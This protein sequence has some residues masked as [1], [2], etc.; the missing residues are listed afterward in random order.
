MLLAVQAACVI[1][2]PSATTAV[3]PR[4]RWWA[5]VWY[6]VWMATCGLVI[7]V[8]LG[9]ALPPQSG[10]AALWILASGLILLAAWQHRKAAAAQPAV[11]HAANDVEARI[12]VGEQQPV[13]GTTH[14]A[15]GASDGRPAQRS[16]GCSKAGLRRCCKGCGSC[17]A[18]SSLFWGAVLG[19]FLVL[20]AANLAQDQLAFPP[21]GRLVETFVT[22]AA[23]DQGVCHVCMRP[24]VT[25]CRALR[26]FH[27]RSV[28]C[29]Q[30]TGCQL[31]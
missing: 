2:V 10:W 1:L 11:E 26:S 29:G 19:L 21:P 16:S 6:T 14:A 24:S 25:L 15:K 23:G 27:E 28:S 18:W 20:Q 8:S 22:T 12:A 4:A 5:W 30:V 13:A 3:R 7:L 31:L 9:I 17:L